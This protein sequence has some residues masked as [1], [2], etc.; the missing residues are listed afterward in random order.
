MHLALWGDACNRMCGPTRARRIQIVAMLSK[1]HPRA[2]FV[3]PVISQG[4]PFAERSCLRS[5]AV[6]GPWLFAKMR[7]SPLALEKKSARGT[8]QTP[9]L[10]RQLKKPLRFTAN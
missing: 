6:C 8:W 9:P 4:T 2:P 7:I 10:Y 1:K 3:K 5:G